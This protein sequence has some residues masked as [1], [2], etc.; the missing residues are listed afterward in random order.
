[1]GL[2]SPTPVS[3]AETD[4]IVQARL[5]WI[6]AASEPEAVILF[7]SAASGKLTEASD[8]D[9]ALIYRD[10]GSKKAGRVA[11][12]S[13]RPPDSWPVDLLFYTREEFA[14]HCKTG[15]VCELILT[16]GKILHGSIGSIL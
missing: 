16:E 13:R 8:L 1:M 3:V 10:A 15:G 12:H 14:R 4:R 9:F 7:G 6:L 11:V 2:L 5:G